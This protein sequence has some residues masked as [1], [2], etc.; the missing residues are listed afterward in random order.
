MRKCMFFEWQMHMKVNVNL[1]WFFYS[2][3]DTLNVFWMYQFNCMFDEDEGFYLP[4]LVKKA[5]T[6]IKNTR[7]NQILHSHLVH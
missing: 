3:D 6:S 5:A 2:F 1:G 7:R 4:T